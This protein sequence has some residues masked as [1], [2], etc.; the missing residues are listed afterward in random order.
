LNTLPEVIKN[1]V[2]LETY[3]NNLK[4]TIDSSTEDIKKTIEKIDSQIANI[5]EFQSRVKYGFWAGTIIA[6]A[7]G[8]SAVNFQ[9]TLSKSTTEIQTATDKSTED[10]TKLTMSSKDEIKDLIKVNKITIASGELAV[11]KNEDSNSWNLD[12]KTN[13]TGD[14]I[15]TKFITF[16]EKL[17]LKSPN[18]VI[19][20]SKVD[21]INDKVSSGKI[22]NTR[23]WISA[24]NITITG[25]T[26]KV[27]TWRD[28]RVSGV[29]INWLA[30]DS[31]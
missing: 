17:F 19:G 15:Y 10:I 21:F 30:Y 2:K 28:T 27:K 31:P 20:L 18:V 3:Q 14:R 26:A 23:L 8:I 9:T 29:A 13:G 4:Q 11:G 22:P 5:R 7:L 6:T 16:P 12:D 1:V 25:F 24:E